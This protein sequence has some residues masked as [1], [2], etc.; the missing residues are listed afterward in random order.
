MV[1][2]VKPWLTMACQRWAL[3]H[4]KVKLLPKKIF[5]LPDLLTAITEHNMIHLINTFIC[6][7]QPNYNK[8][9]TKKFEVGMNFSVFERSLFCSPRLDQKYNKKTVI[10][11]ILLQFKV[12]CFLC[13]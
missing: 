3:V 12:G 10:L 6:T 8:L 11:L 7:N 2:I 9:D 13:I 1:T 4:L 5:F